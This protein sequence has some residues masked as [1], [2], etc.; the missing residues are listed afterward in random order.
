MTVAFVAL[1]AGFMFVCLW[2]VLDRI[3]SAL[4]RI[5]DAQETLAGAVCLE[6]AQ[7]NGLLLRIPDAPPEDL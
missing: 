2:S 1:V 7:R 6:H 4:H 3:A 5:A